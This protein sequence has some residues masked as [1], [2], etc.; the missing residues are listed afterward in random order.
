MKTIITLTIVAILGAAAL[1]AEVST[2]GGASALLQAP[3]VKAGAPLAAMKCATCKS[4]FVTV[5][6]PSF[7]GSMPETALVERHGCGSCGT[8]WATSG[9]GKAKVD[10]AVHT[11]GG[12]KM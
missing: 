12:C 8:K 2:K 9:H 10:A 4:D 3:A 5:R 1:R 6:V 11:C 7:K